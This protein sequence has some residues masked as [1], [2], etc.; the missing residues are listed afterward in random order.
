MKSGEKIFFIAGAQRCGTSYLAQMLSKHPDILMAH[1]E[2]PEPKFFLNE[3]EYR[4]GK[5][6]YLQKFFK[7]RA[8]QEVLGEKSTSYIESKDA[9]LKIKQMFPAAKIIISL[10]NPVERAI[11]NYHFSKAN[12]VETRSIREVFLQNKPIAFNTAKFSVSPFDYFGRG[13]YHRYIQE[14]FE[15]FGRENVKVLVFERMIK[16]TT[17]REKLF[18]FLEVSPMAQEAGIGEEKVNESFVKETIDAEVLKHL[19]E[20]FNAPNKDLEILLN[21]DL[22]LWNS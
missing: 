17:E 6:Y 11:S 16:E 7:E 3:Q 12:L 10:R 5:E 2:F 22:S 9:A 18:E 13:E 19:R 14:Y 8:G 21:E 15:V 20:Y 1:P 4:K